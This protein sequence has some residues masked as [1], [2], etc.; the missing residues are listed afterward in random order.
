MADPVITQKGNHANIQLGDKLVAANVPN[1]KN[2]IR[3]LIEV[4]MIFIEVDCTHLESLDSTGIGLLIAAHNSLERID[5]R[6]TI[7][8][9]STDVYDLLCSM[10]LDRRVKITRQDPK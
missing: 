1:L 6:L 2:V 9:T 7:V 4:G 5:G 3:R 10:R 8:Q